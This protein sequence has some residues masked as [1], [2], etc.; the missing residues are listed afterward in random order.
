MTVICPISKVAFLA[1]AQAGTQ[2]KTRAS[3]TAKSSDKHRPRAHEPRGGLPLQVAGIAYF[4]L[5]Q[6]KNRQKPPAFGR[7]NPLA[8]NCI[9]FFSD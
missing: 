2:V 9:R 3:D 4:L 5:S 6:T 8:A 1:A 7:A